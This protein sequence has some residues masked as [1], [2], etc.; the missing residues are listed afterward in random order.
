MRPRSVTILGLLLLLLTISASGALLLFPVG[1]PLA[2]APSLL[3]ASPVAIGWVIFGLLLAYVAALT[4]AAIAVLRMRP[5]ARVAYQSVAIVLSLCFAAFLF[6][7][8][9]PTPW[10]LYVVCFGSF[11]G[12][13]WLGWR[14]VRDR[15][16]A[17]VP[18]AF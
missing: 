18:S 7:V 14:V 3:A 2:V 15:I 8:R 5:W 16:P 13:V 17:A 12:L 9:I 1:R 11:G 6:L 4:A 10:W